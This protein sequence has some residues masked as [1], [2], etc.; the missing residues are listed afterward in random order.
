MVA[1]YNVS[2]NTPIDKIIVHLKCLVRITDVVWMRKRVGVSCS[3]TMF[4]TRILIHIEV[5]LTSSGI[6]RHERTS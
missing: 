3:M 5:C 4:C 6:F 1:S 2:L